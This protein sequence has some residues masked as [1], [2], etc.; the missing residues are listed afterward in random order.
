MGTTRA[1]ELPSMA[2]ESAFSVGVRM[3]K[4]KQLLV[5]F[6]FILASPG[7]VGAGIAGLIFG[8][9]VFSIACFIGAVV[10]FLVTMYLKRTYKISLPL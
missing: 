4:F 5:V 3:N 1:R 7:L 6:S 2:V 8:R 9:M 10:L